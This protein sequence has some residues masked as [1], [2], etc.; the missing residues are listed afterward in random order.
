MKSIED[1]YLEILKY[2]TVSWTNFWFY[3]LNLLKLVLY[4]SHYFS[5]FK[6]TDDEIMALVQDQF[7]EFKMDLKTLKDV[8]VNTCSR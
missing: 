5:S 2:V 8:T 1:P 3:H 6:F 7:C 4:F